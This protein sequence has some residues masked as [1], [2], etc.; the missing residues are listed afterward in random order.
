MQFEHL[1]RAEASLC[2][3]SFRRWSGQPCIAALGY[4]PTASRRKNSHDL[5]LENAGMTSAGADFS[6]GP[7]RSCGGEPAADMLWI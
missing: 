6:A 4:W 2:R 5:V 1:L 7:Q 3:W